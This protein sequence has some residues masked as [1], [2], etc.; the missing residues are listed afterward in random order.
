VTGLSAY[1]SLREVLVPAILAGVIAAIF[2][3]TPQIQLWMVGSPSNGIYAVND[4]D[5]SSYA[6]YV[7]SLIDGKPRVNSPFSGAESRP[8]HRLNESIFSIQVLASYPIAIVARIFGLSAGDAFIL[9]SALY[10]A[11][12]GLAIFWLFFVLF[13]EPWLAAAGAVVVL[14]A[15]AIVAGQGALLRWLAPDAIF[16]GLPFPFARRAAPLMGFPAL[17]VFIASVFR[18]LE[19]KLFR[20]RAFFLALAAIAFVTLVYSYFYLWTTAAAWVFTLGLLVLIVRPADWTRKLG[21]L[22]ILT[23]LMV[24]AVLPYAYL[25]ADRSATT[26]SVQLL[27]YTRA[28]DLVRIPTILGS[29][30]AVAIG[31]FIAFG[32][33]KARETRTIFFLSFALVGVVVFNQQIVTGRSLQPFHYQFFTI[34]YLVLLALLSGVFLFLERK[35]QHSYYRKAIL[36]IGLIGILIGYRE[37][38]GRE[39]IDGVRASI[40]PVAEKIKESSQDGAGLVLSFDLAKGS[41]PIADEIPALSSHPVVWAPHQRV[42]GDLSDAD[43]IDRFHYFLYFQDKDP[44]WLRTALT[45]NDQTVVQGVFGWRGKD[46]GELSNSAGVSRAEIDEAVEAFRTFSEQPELKK[47]LE[48]PISYVVVPRFTS[49]SFKHLD[50]CHERELI[51]TFNMYLLFKIHD[52]GSVACP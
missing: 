40:V 42:F 12:S 13:K 46:H 49:V 52:R 9:A 19:A 36:L 50:A 51:G 37:A 41:W 2:A 11:L 7:Q 27:E 32:K 48:Y 8:G 33:V 34:N 38:A 20:T 31:V 3:L 15:G 17:F 18:S 24:L 21:T 22:L 26:D 10:G 25:L 6:A 35:S 45:S 4:F 39:S 29:L 28:P 44:E 16:Y 1:D 43:S 5:E 47:G 23:G 14:A 30:F